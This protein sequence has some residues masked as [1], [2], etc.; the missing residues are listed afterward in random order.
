M[1]F[2][3][4]VLLESV[5]INKLIEMR[6]YNIKILISFL[7]YFFCNDYIF[8]IELKG[9]YVFEVNNLFCIKK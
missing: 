6:I 5:R 2:W 8:S 4:V 7:I 1:N 3:V 9:F